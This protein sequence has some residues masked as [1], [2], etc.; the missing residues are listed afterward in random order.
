M[1]NKRRYYGIEIKNV[2]IFV[3]AIIASIV[4]SNV[5]IFNES[6]K[7]NNISSVGLDGIIVWAQSRFLIIGLIPML[8]S[9]FFLMVSKRRKN[10]IFIVRS[11]SRK[12]IYINDLAMMIKVT[13]FVMLINIVISTINATFWNGGKFLCMPL[14]DNSEIDTYLEAAV[15][16]GFC[17][18][19]FNIIL[20]ICLAYIIGVIE[21]MIVLS[22]NQ[23]IYYILGKRMPALVITYII[24]IVLGVF[25][26]S[27]KYAFY[28]GIKV[29]AGTYYRETANFTF[30]FIKIF[31]LCI[32]ET[33]LFF[34]TLYFAR[35]KDY[36]E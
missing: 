13:M 29:A 11:S 23:L 8:I 36:L 5:L 9:T 33:I 22:I 28:F 1:L 26:K 35:K 34:I 20:A 24:S 30:G 17:E 14:M 15:I 10:S 25:P 12:A 31:E 16:E 21:I 3:I 4:I 19:K 18:E 32:I 7:L 6:E 27:S 2:I